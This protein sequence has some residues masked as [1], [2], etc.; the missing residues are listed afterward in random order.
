MASLGTVIVKR[1]QAMTNYC[2]KERIVLFSDVSKFPQVP[3][4]VV[5]A[6]GPS[7]ISG[8][9]QY[10]IIAHAN[11]GHSDKLENFILNEIDGILTGGIDDEQGSRYK[12]YPNGFTDVTP[13]PTDNT[14]FMERMYYV[15]L[16]VD[17]N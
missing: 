7:G 13:S 11:Q 5:K 17:N 12:L 14:F 8:T 1:L 9:R 10:R 3:Y 4:I 6:D 15:P 16:R 2:P